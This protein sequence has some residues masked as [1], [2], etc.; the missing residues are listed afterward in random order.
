MLSVAVLP[1]PP[2]C[3]V[4]EFDNCLHFA[5][6]LLFSDEVIRKRL[7][8]DGEGVSNDDRRINTLAKMFIKWLDSKDGA[9]EDRYG[10]RC[11]LQHT[12][13]RF[14]MTI[15]RGPWGVVHLY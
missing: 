11:V 15:E 9:E 8:V 10:V 4:D 2:C 5:A 13:C 1:K 7:L 3:A 12:N 14:S 6:L